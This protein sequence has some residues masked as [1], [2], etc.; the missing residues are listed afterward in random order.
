MA[1]LEPKKYAPPPE[2]RDARQ[3]DR[4]GHLPMAGGLDDQPIDY[5]DRCAWASAVDRAFRGY[6]EAPKLAQWIGSN[7]DLHDLYKEVMDLLVKDGLV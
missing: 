6:I 4:W 5:L 7:P 1:Y 2:L 3:I